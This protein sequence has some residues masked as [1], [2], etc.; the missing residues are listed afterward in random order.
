MKQIYTGYQW[1]PMTEA[2][3]EIMEA[4]RIVDE[5]TDDAQAGDIV[6]DD[7]LEAFRE[8]WAEFVLAIGEAFGIDRFL[9]WISKQFKDEAPDKCL[10]C[11]GDSQHNAELI[12]EDGTLAYIDGLQL[13]I[14]TFAW[15][16]SATDVDTKINYCPMCGRKLEVS[17]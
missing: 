15:D 1:R 14:E 9:N 11:I 8:A 6:E 4:N 3:L 10:Y 2:E 5:K 17:K 16:G 12:N 7:E 13:R